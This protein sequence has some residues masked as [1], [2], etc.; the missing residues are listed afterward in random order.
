MPQRPHGRDRGT[1]S[2]RRKSGN[3]SATARTR[4]IAK[5][6][7]ARSSVRASPRST[8]E[9]GSTTRQPPGWRTPRLPTTRQPPGWREPA[10]ARPAPRE[11]GPTLD[12][13]SEPR[14][15]RRSP[16]ARCPNPP[17]STNRPPVRYSSRRERLGQR[18]PPARPSATE[19]AY[20]ID[21]GSRT[22]GPDQPA[23]KLG[24]NRTGQAGT[25]PGLESP[26]ECTRPAG[27]RGC[28]PTRKPLRGE[29]QGYGKT[30]PS[31]STDPTAS[32]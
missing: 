23:G 15:E 5:S 8:T 10:R 28:A 26:S 1:R 27:E 12:H 13:H 29:R 2:R 6:R 16:R 30:E 22:N 9:H 24:G 21:T 7:R 19:I 31:R 25:A 4:S 32:T 17:S 20:T 3:P 18:P 14:S 11:T